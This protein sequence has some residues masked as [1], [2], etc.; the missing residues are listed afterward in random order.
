[1]SRDFAVRS[2]WF[3][4]QLPATHV[5]HLNIILIFKYFLFAL[6]H[7]PSFIIFYYAIQSIDIA[8][9]ILE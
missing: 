1:M 6:V 3:V 5:I 2:Y 9:E 4:H 8:P 7:W